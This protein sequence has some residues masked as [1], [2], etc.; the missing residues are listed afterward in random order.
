[1]RHSHVW[2]AFPHQ[3]RKTMTYAWYDGCTFALRVLVFFFFH[4]NIREKDGII[5]KLLTVFP[6]SKKGPKMEFLLEGIREHMKTWSLMHWE[7]SIVYPVACWTKMA[8]HPF[9]SHSGVSGIWQKHCFNSLS[10]TIFKKLYTTPLPYHV[11]L[12][13]TSMLLFLA[14]HLSKNCFLPPYVYSNTSH[15][16]RPRPKP[17]PTS[18]PWSLQSEMISPLSELPQQ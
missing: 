15:P 10:W 11:W 8:Q 13:L 2:L 3:S 1:M 7:A 6:I 16:S 9:S 4:L 17:L 14:F 5:L 12:F 18:F